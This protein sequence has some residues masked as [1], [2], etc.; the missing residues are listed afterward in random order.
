MKKLNN[1]FTKYGFWSIVF[2][3]FLP[4][5]FDFIGILAGASN[6]NIKRFFLATLIGKTIKMLMIAYAGFF[7]GIPMIDFINLWLENKF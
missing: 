5:P 1:F 4:F 7:V 2:L 6:Y 3:A